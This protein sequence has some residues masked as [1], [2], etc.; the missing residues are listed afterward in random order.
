[1]HV[2]Y[3]KL[4][5]TG[6]EVSKVC[7]GAMSYGEPDRGTHLWSLPEDQ[8]RPFIRQALDGG[9]NFFD[10]ANVYSAGSSEEILGRALKDFVP[11]E[12]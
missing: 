9:V 3:V 5:S 2:H 6:L 4:G 7:L 10:T 8:A 11:R 1:M 12:D